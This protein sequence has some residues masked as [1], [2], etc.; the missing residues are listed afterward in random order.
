M[1]FF[2]IPISF[3]S[4]IDYLI[5]QRSGNFFWKGQDRKKLRFGGPDSKLEEIYMSTSQKTGSKF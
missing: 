2:N 1:I 5:L 3:D 4:K